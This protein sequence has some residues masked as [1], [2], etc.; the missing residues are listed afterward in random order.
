[1]S[2]KI[3]LDQPLSDDDRMYLQERDRYREIEENDRR[4][5][6]R[7]KRDDSNLE[8][9]IAE[10]EEQLAVLRSRKVQR[11]L[12]AEQ[13]TVG[14]KDNTV[15]NGEGGLEEEEDNYDDLNLQQLKDEI[16]KRNTDR[17]PEDRISMAG[18]KAELVERLREDDEADE[19]DEGE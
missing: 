2:R 1:M 8:D 14:V 18:K 4:F 12:A 11:D 13:E 15:V 5:G 6:A 9:Q 17:D 10:L 3:D 16:A 19:E 7:P